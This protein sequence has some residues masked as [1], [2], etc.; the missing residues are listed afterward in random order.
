MERQKVRSV[1]AFDT[2]AQHQGDMQTSGDDEP[3]EEGCLNAF[4]HYNKTY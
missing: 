1:E 3:M 4:T 2:L